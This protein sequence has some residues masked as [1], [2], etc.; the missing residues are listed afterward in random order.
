MS[1]GGHVFDMIIRLRN[2]K[3]LRKI[4]YFKTK[5]TYSRHSKSINVD[6]RTATKAERDEIRKRVKD[7]RIMEKWKSMLAFIL[8]LLLTATIIFLLVRFLK[9]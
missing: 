6:F 8:S 2:N 1:G 9:P 5:D 7:E 4:S 3:N